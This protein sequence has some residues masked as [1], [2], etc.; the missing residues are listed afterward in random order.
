MINNTAFD[1]AGSNFWQRSRSNPWSACTTNSIPCVTP[2]SFIDNRNTWLKARE[3][4]ESFLCSNY[5]R[6]VQ[7]YFG[8]SGGCMVQ[9]QDSKV[10]GFKI[11]FMSFPYTSQQKIHTRV[12]THYVCRIQCSAIGKRW[13]LPSKIIH[14]AFCCGLMVIASNQN[15][16]VCNSILNQ[17]NYTFLV[18]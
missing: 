2:F 9:G 7:F 14:K 1:L 4:K 6:E 16:W 3:N 11:T 5:L 15:S 8:S 12:K 17:I 13:F 18:Y 10:T